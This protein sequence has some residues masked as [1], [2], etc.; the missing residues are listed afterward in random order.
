MDNTIRKQYKTVNPFELK[1]L[2]NLV[3]LTGENGT[4]NVAKI[5]DD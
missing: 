5:P 2:P 3:V 4:G 1:D